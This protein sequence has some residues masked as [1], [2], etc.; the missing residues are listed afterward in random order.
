MKKLYAILSILTLV[1]AGCSN[2][3]PEP[4]GREKLHTQW[5]NARAGVLYGLAKQQFDGGNPVDA[6]KSLDEAIRLQPDNVSLRILSARVSIEQGKLESAVKELDNVRTI[7]PT[8]AEADYLM[9]VIYQRWQKPDNALKWYVEAS[10]KKPAEL[11]YVMARAETLI[12]QGRGDEA[13]DY[14]Q[15]RLSY[16]ENAAPIRDLAAQLLLWAGKRQE[17]ITLFREASMLAPED[18][19]IREHL[20][21]A[22]YRTGQYAET[23]TV[24][25]KLMRDEPFAK[26]TDL[27]L[28]MA[29]SL[30]NVNRPADARAILQD[31]AQNQPAEPRIWL[32]LAR[33]GLAC[34]DN[35]RAEMSIAKAIALDA[36]NAEAWVLMGYLRIRQDKLNDAQAAFQKAAALDQ[37]DA[38]AVCMSG[39]VLEKQGKA[40]QAM[41][42]YVK[43]LHLKPNDELATTLLAQVQTGD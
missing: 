19:Q 9:G 30:L 21:L 33:T 2:D 23:I 42:L 17:A 26:R 41:D 28:V 20:A 32:A 22:L 36:S 24:L 5:N 35:D 38:V 39:Y 25:E 6:R 4:T 18:G 37:N 40:R 10:E 8:N 16:F 12:S 15:E 43:A 29:E 7:D 14:V 11:A 34:S 27:L 13:L 1:V 31:L 3:K